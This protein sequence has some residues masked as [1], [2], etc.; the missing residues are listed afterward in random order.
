VQAP[1][2]A[3]G[4]QSLGGQLTAPPAVAAQPNRIS[5]PVAPLFIATSTNKHLHIR[6]LRAGWREISPVATCIAAHAAVITG[7][8]S[9]GPFT[10]A[11][12]CRGTNNAL[13]E[14]STTL[15]ASGLP[16]FTSGWTPTRA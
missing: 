5:A 8:A 7:T 9:T 13:W 11:V 10:L 2:L 1:H 12:A 3:R 16:Q 14:N 15:P 6:S 4:W